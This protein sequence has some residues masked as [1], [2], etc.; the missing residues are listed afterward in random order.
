MSAPRA[1]FVK[2]FTLI[3]LMVVIGI[4]AILVSIGYSVYNNAQKSSLDA[5]R[6]A[7]IDSIAKAYEAKYSPLKNKYVALEEADFTE[8]KIPRPPENPSGFYEGFN[9]GFGATTKQGASF[10]VCA[11]L[12]NAPANTTCSSTNPNCYCKSSSQGAPIAPQTAAA[13][14]PEGLP[15]FAAPPPSTPNCY[16]IA[17]GAAAGSAADNNDWVSW[18]NSL[19]STASKITISANAG[20]KFRETTSATTAQNILNN[21]KNRVS[22]NISDGGN[23]WHGAYSNSTTSCG[24]SF[25]FGTGMMCS[26][27]SDIL[28]IPAFSSKVLCT[29]SCGATCTGQTQVCVTP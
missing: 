6:K 16:T 4:I 26:C 19:P 22:F 12:S 1:K 15:G 11:K 29:S 10:L 23:T 8:G 21:M 28:V 17:N 9:G 13:T 25:S 14:A 3:E 5:R 2:A 7:D 24:S 27:S 20:V 18:W